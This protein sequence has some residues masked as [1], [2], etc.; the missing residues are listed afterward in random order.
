MA[1]LQ[2]PKA[3]VLVVGAGA[4]KEADLPVGSELK[5]QIAKKFAF[6]FGHRGISDGGD[7]LIARALYHVAAS[8]KDL[9][10]LV[11]AAWH[12]RDAMPQAISIDN[13]IDSHRE[14]ERIAVCGKLAIVRC[15]LLAEDKSKLQFDRSNIYNKMKFEPLEATWFNSFFQILTENCGRRDLADRLQRVAIISFN[16]DR[17]IEHYLYHALQ[18]Y[19]GMAAEEAAEALAILE[20]H[21]PYGRAGTL[22]WVD[23]ENGIDFGATPSLAQLV[24]LS[25][26]LRTF[27]EGVDPSTSDI[28]AIRA[29]LASAKRIAFLGFAF[30]RLNLE[31]LFP[32]LP[33]GTLIPTSPRIFSTALGISKSDVELI[34]QDLARMGGF[35]LGLIK[36][37]TDLT[38]EKLFVEYRRSMSLC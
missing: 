26:Q 17:C 8:D 13:F 9:N 38:C 32:G 35:S 16:Y 18:N 11:Q 37:H 14:N 19:Y 4:S 31:L 5:S 6:R 2:N 15:I 29:L 21:H 23:R 28:A 20:I 22:P 27:T 7:D 33:P 25:K 24:A 30:H 1:T 3:L 10:A 12:I 34:S 36:M